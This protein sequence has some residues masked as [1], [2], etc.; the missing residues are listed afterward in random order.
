[1]RHV[2]DE[3][4]DNKLYWKNP[5]YYGKFFDGVQFA[6]YPYLW[7]DPLRPHVFTI[8]NAEYRR[9]GFDVPPDWEI[10]SNTREVTFHDN[11]RA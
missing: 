5:V 6:H 10:D 3:V 8:S 9:G 2:D 4:I 7:P 1:M 11:A